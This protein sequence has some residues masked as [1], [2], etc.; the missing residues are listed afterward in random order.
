MTLLPLLATVLLSAE[1]V[2]EINVGSARIINAGTLTSA[3]KDTLEQ[4]LAS[5]PNVT[6]VTLILCVGDAPQVTPDRAAATAADL[7]KLVATLR[8]KL[9]RSVV[10]RSLDAT[11][12][13]TGVRAVLATHDVR[14]ASNEAQVLSVSGQVSAHTQD[15]RD[16]PL[17]AESVV[18]SDPRSKRRRV[19]VACSGFRMERA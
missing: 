10:G 19:R 7:T 14:G 1:P 15:G 6:M 4:T 5:V 18:P 11:A 12:C 8:P 3:A 9:A 16:V 2:K 17:F 13:P